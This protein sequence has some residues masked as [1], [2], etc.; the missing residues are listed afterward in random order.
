[1]FLPLAGDLPLMVDHTYGRKTGHW[2]EPIN[3]SFCYLL[4]LSHRDF[5][6]HLEAFSLLPQFQTLKAQFTYYLGWG[7]LGNIGITL[8]YHTQT[9]IFN[10]C[11]A[12]ASSFLQLNLDDLA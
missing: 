9:Y 2:Y 6:Y 11:L 4:K 3:L 1:M 7:G 5:F 12:F 8:Y 10:L